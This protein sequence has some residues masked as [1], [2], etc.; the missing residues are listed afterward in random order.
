[1]WWKPLLQPRGSVPPSSCSESVPLCP[2]HSKGD[3]GFVADKPFALVAGSFSPLDF[4]LTL[5]PV[6]WGLSD[7]HSGQEM[8]VVPEQLPSGL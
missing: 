8:K 4:W 7:G 6:D 3:L 2:V 1:M 5:F